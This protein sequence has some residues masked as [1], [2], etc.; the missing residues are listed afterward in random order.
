MILEALVT[1]ADDHGRV[2]LAPMG[3]DVAPDFTEI[4]LKPF[5][6]STTYENLQTS[7]K[8]VIHVT[9][10]ACLIARCA[11]GDVPA[12]ATTHPLAS[13][14]RFHILDDCCRYFAVEIESWSDDPQR[15]VARC[16]IHEARTVRDFFGFNRA[17]HALIEAAIL[18]TRVH[19]LP[20][21]QMERQI[22]AL[23]P[24]VEKTGTA[25]HLRTFEQLR[26]YCASRPA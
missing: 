5:K 1:T 14:S 23:R 19:L 2:N 9:D 13:D 18:A 20:V 11:I 8:A 7:G 16:R 21:D 4:A 25:Q 22:E 6:T 10:D 15:P 3:P 26:T 12:T 17:A 24:L